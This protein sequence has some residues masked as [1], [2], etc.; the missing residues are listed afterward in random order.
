MWIIWADL[1]Y[2]LYTQTTLPE[3]VIEEPVA[4]PVLVTSVSCD[5]IPPPKPDFFAPP[6]YEVATKLPTY[7][8]V[9]REKHLEEQNLS[10]PDSQNSRVSRTQLIYCG[11]ILHRRTNFKER[12]CV[13][14]IIA[15]VWSK[16]KH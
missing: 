7:E 3:V 2:V 14:K 13:Q 9:Q 11:T 5:D 1:C 15:V 10:N 8:E 6:P 12:K 16:Q 4:T